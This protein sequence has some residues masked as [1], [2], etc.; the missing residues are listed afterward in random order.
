MPR[1]YSFR[2]LV[3]DQ[4]GHEDEA[5]VTASFSRN[6]FLLILDHDFE[7]HG[8]S[9]DGLHGRTGNHKDQ[10]TRDRKVAKAL[11]QRIFRLL[12]EATTLY[13]VPDDIN[14]QG[15]STTMIGHFL[16]RDKHLA[17]ADKAL[18]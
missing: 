12:S 4:V 15:N 16:E 2:V 17:A 1:S 10:Y 13:F 7:L 8:T 5:S 9:G 14:G 11:A 6:L 18:V 3:R